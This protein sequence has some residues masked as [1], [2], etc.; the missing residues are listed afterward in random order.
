MIM[1]NNVKT[2]KN[3]KRNEMKKKYRNLLKF[4]VIAIAFFS[5]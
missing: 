3:E 4:L 1:E 5:D 2:R